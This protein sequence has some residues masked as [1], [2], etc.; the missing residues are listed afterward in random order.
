MTRSRARAEAG[1]TRVVALVTARCR[2]C[3]VAHSKRVSLV[4]VSP[5]TVIELNEWSA[6][7]ASNGRRT[8]RGSA[9]SVKT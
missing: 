5:S 7:A 8:S 2:A 4:E 6:A 1:E 3:P 9:A